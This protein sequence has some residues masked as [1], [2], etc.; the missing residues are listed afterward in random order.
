ML[1][2]AFKR[3]NAPIKEVFRR[4]IISSILFFLNLNLAA[5]PA[6][7]CGRN[8]SDV[9]KVWLAITLGLHVQVTVVLLQVIEWKEV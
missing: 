9:E 8:G 5:P 4:K 1:C 2:I 6:C 7:A 3:S